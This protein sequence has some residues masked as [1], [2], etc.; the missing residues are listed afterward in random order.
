MASTGPYRKGTHATM[1][2]ASDLI[3]Q[4]HITIAPENNLTTMGLLHHAQLR[5]QREH[6][7]CPEHNVDNHTRERW[8]VDYI[9]HKLTNYDEI[10]ARS[11][12]QRTASRI[13]NAVL[14]LIARTYPTYRN[15]CQMQRVPIL[16]VAA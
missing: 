9:R 14:E 3:R 2:T 16:G 15:A 6:I 1:D 7:T 5:R 11:D 10:V 4:L 13:K 8:A 12:S